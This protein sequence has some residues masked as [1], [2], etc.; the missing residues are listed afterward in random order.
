MFPWCHSQASES[1]AYALG[2]TVYSGECHGI[3]VTVDAEKATMGI[4]W[5]D[6]DGYPI[7]YPMDA[8]YLRKGLPWQT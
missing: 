7:T 5:S 2:D 6:G 4:V 1:S 8:S 3:V